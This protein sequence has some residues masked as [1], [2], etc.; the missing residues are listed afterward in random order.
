MKTAGLDIGTTGCKLT[1]FSEK[2]KD[3][4]RAYRDYPVTRGGNEHEVDVASIMEGMLSVIRV[5]AEKYPDIGGI[6]VTSFGETFVFTDG[7]GKPLHRA[8]LYTDPRRKR[9][10]VARLP[11]LRGFV[12]MRCTACPR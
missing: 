9:W 1:V 3:I 8:M 6:G 11:P 7:E 12:P 5:M 4:D 2:G 10:T